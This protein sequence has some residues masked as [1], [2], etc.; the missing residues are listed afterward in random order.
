MG[1]RGKLK[2]RCLTCC[3]ELSQ[4]RRENDPEKV[5]LIHRAS[6][7]K[8]KYGITLG[9][10]DVMYLKQDGKCGICKTPQEHLLQRLA[11][12]HDHSTPKIRGL[13]CS[14]C[15]RALGLLKDNPNYLSNAIAYLKDN[16]GNVCKSI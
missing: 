9:E 16:E 7:F 12:D 8:R 5:Y 15:N 2:S 10:Y 11:V 4:L 14:S 3:R 13:L 1:K 6:Q